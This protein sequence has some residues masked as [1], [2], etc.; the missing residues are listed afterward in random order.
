[1]KIKRIHFCFIR[2]KNILTKR[3]FY[4]NF[5]PAYFSG[6]K[7]L[8]LNSSIPI[9]TKY[10]ILKNIPL[11]FIGIFWV[12]YFFVVFYEV[13][14][15]LYNYYILANY[16]DPGINKLD[17][18]SR[19][20]ITLSYFLIDAIYPI[21]FYLLYDFYSKGIFHLKI[22]VFIFFSNFFCILC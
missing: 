14:E 7:A 22:Y 10:S 20:F 19:I 16:G 2:E 17:L 11:Y 13:L 8:N 4:T 18:V 12:L 9:S 5:I 3:S 15:F 21:S 1:M 6:S